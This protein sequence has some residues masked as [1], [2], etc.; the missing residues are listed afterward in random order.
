MLNRKEITSELSNLLENHLNP[1]KDPRI[2]M[3]KEITF[4][5]ATLHPIRVDYMLFKPI[6]NTA[7]GIEHGDFY[8]YEVKS[9]KE[10]FESGHGLNF[11]CDFN[12]IVTTKEVF[13]LKKQVIPY[14]V[15]VYVKEGDSLV[16]VKKARRADRKYS[17]SEML[18]M[19]F[20]SANRENFK[21]N[22]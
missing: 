2:Y 15:G 18:L 4:D 3:A 16:S 14:C 17:L 1:R 12:Y 5:Y 21:K 22:K 11:I 19:M 13:E 7:S 6:N 8:G 10:D 20:R 9:C